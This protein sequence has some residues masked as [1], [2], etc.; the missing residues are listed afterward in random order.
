MLPHWN[1]GTARHGGKKGFNW[2]EH[3]VIVFD[4]RQMIITNAHQHTHTRA[5]GEF[6]RLKS[7]YEMVTIMTFY[8]CRLFH[9]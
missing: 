4:G 9:S 1:G 6:H 3:V 8:Q 2:I 5:R 7:N